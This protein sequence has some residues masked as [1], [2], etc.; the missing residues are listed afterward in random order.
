MGIDLGSSGELVEVLG[1]HN[2]FAVPCSEENNDQG[3]K[4]IYVLYSVTLPDSKKTSYQK[5]LDQV[6]YF[7][8][9]K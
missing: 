7:Y 6:Y 9:R 2:S 1:L 4:K 8:F 5:G 3:E